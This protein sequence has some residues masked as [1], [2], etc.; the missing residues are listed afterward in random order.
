M[1]KE[2]LD[3]MVGLMRDGYGLD[4]D[5]FREFF[6]KVVRI[7]HKG[8]A[9]AILD[10]AKG[11][12]EVTMKVAKVLY[13]IRQLA[14]EENLLHV[15]DGYKASDLLRMDFKYMEA[16]DLAGF[17]FTLHQVHTDDLIVDTM[18][19]CVLN[20]YLGEFSIKKL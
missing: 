19:G 14:D 10:C 7:D 20:A 12:T 17:H 15:F 13:T 3:D 8:G 2:K 9:D 6:D 4:I 11:F 1:A 5:S 18:V 16:D